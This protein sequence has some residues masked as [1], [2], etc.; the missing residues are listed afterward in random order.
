[1]CYIVSFSFSIFFF[2]VK[3][4][5]NKFSLIQDLGKCSYL[6]TISS[7][8]MAMCKGETLKCYHHFLSIRFSAKIHV[9]FLSLNFSCVTTSDCIAAVLSS[10]KLNCSL[11]IHASNTLTPEGIIYIQ[12]KFPK[13]AETLAF[14]YVLY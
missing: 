6:A 12:C 3:V 5:S 1:M 4:H 8:V 9:I 7:T 14:I 13:P 11:V 10:D 2:H